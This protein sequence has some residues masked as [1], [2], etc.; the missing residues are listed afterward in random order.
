LNTKK[1]DADKMFLDGVVKDS[2]KGIFIIETQSGVIVRAVLSGKI[3][4]NA[5]KIL[6]GDKVTVEVTPYEP[7][8]GRITFRF[9][10]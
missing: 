8:K 5:V 4:Q 2:C 7:Q 1:S 10:P 3:R 9:K 6:V